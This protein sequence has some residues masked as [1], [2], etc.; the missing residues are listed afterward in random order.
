[1]AQKSRSS[2]AGSLYMSEAD[3][4]VR[5]LG[6]DAKR[7]PDLAAILERE[8]LPRIDSLTGKRFWPA[9]EAC[10]ISR[11]GLTATRIHAHAD[12]LETWK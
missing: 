10:L 7:W 2:D 1:M 3:I 9:V 4:A 12:G 11:N 5:V 6:D 8:G